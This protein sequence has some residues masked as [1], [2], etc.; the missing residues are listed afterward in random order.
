MV[1]LF[2][3]YLSVWCG[4][5]LG[6]S[7]IWLTLF[8][9]YLAIPLSVSA[10]VVEEE[11]TG[12]FCQSVEEDFVNKTS[13]I[14][15]HLYKTP[16]HLREG[17][18]KPVELVF[19]AGEEA[20][21]F[22][23]RIPSCG[24]KV[25]FRGKAKSA[26]L[27]QVKAGSF[28]EASTDQELEAANL[29][30]APFGEQKT[31]AIMVD[32]QNSSVPCAESDISNIMFN[33]TGSVNAAFHD[34]S[35]GSV[36]LSGDV[37]RVKL[38]GN[39]GSMCDPYSWAS[40]AE[41]LVQSA[42]F[43]VSE[44]PR[45]VFFLPSNIPCYWGGLGNLGGSPSRAWVR[46]CHTGIAIHEVGHNLTMHHSASHMN[47]YYSEYGD[48]SDP[49]GG[50]LVVGFNAPHKDHMDWVNAKNITT[51]ST[52]TISA[53]NLDPN[54]VTSPQMITFA[55]PDTGDW[56]YVS[57]RNKADF[58]G[59]LPS[60][61]SNKVSIH[62]FKGGII[63][64][65]L[66]GTL[67]L[68]QSYY[69]ST[70]KFTVSVLNITNDTATVKFSIAGA[71]VAPSLAISPTLKSGAPGQIQSYNVAL[72]NRDSG[73]SPT[74]FNL[75]FMGPANWT[76]VLASQTITLSP[77]STGTTTLDITPPLDEK[78]GYFS[79]GVR[80]SDG[81][82]P[83]HTVYA[84]ANY[85]VIAPDTTAPTVRVVFPSD[86]RALNSKLL[87]SV[88]I[89]CFGTDQGRLAAAKIH[90]NGANILYRTIPGSAVSA[91]WSIRVPMTSLVTGSN[92]VSCEGIDKAG[93]IGTSTI[94]VIKY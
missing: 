88:S 18:G 44:Y 31:L 35:Y 75:E 66:L 8:T 83:V 2:L 26:K 84:K 56:Y 49:M 12:A 23:S 47:G 28:I 57:F 59:G 90:L 11:F 19:A 70:N 27:V 89:I 81:I 48:S 22:G 20:K 80:V 29:S 87:R 24:T 46:T 94:N 71:P 61:F 53:L 15:N 1:S 38:S 33:G 72:R 62:R 74:T 25:R 32:F 68:G 37:A 82:N 6:T 73:S 10:E 55:K 16:K 45:R 14:V 7:R 67:G 65:V 5:S 40:Q 52:E 77:G 4:M 34:A 42:G 93:N 76:G 91:T 41:S 50:A 54:S 13:K 9:I 39:L 17:R 43:N 60:T 79:F 3:T 69:D 92:A 36:Y 86:G 78:A 63:Q 58:D 51:N 30:S 85:R 21:L 64:T